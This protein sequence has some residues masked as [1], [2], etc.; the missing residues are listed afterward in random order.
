MAAFQIRKF[1]PVCI[2]FFVKNYL[3]DYS[4]SWYICTETQNVGYV[5]NVFIQ[6]QKWGLMESL[7]CS[8]KCVGER[9][10]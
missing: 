8:E 4:E 7:S 6:V 10:E 5:E 2:V 3:F 9:N 1:N